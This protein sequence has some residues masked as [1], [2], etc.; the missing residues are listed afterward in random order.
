MSF[1]QVLKMISS[2]SLR[3]LRRSLGLIFLLSFQVCLAWS[4]D[5]SF[6]SKQRYKTV[7]SVS[8]LTKDK[9]WFSVSSLAKFKGCFRTSQDKVRSHPWKVSGAVEVKFQTSYKHVLQVYL[10]QFQ[11]FFE[12][13]LQRCVSTV[14]IYLERRFLE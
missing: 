11:N 9:T 8:P 7:Y 5:L 2:T 13:E 4:S 12:Y 3:T 1:V 14:Q 10:V 6:V